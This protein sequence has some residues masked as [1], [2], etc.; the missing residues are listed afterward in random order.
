MDDL[1]GVIERITFSNQMTGYTVAKL[2]S[3]KQPD[4]VTVV[5]SMPGLKPGETVRC[6]GSWKRHL[7]HGSQ[8]VVAAVKQEAPSDIVGIRKYLGSGLIKGIGPVYAEK[9][10]DYFGI[11]TLDIISQE[12]ERLF[13][14]KGLGKK[15]VEKIID[16][17][18]EQESIRDVMVFLQAH[19]VSPAYA[20]KIFRFYKNRS[21]EVIQENPYRL[22]REI[23]GIGFKMADSIAQSLGFE[24]ESARRIAAGVIYVLEQLA[25]EGH[26]CFPLNPFVEKAAQILEIDQ[27]L[28]QKEIEALHTADEVQVE[29][30]VF[31]GDLL[32]FIW[33]TVAYRS[34]L[35]IAKLLREL[36]QSPS[37]LRKVDG[38][39]ALKWVENELSIELATNQ[40]QAVEMALLEKVSLIT[41]GPGTGKSTIT[42]AILA[43]YSKLT[44]NILLLAPTGRAAKRMQEITGQNAYTIHAKL[45]VDFQK[46]GFRRGKDLPLEADLIIC[47]EA[48][49]VDTNLFYSLLK[50]VPTS[51]HLILVGDIFQ[52]PSVG[53]GNVLKDLIN[54]NR[55]STVTLNQIF[56]QAEGSRIITNSHLINS[57]TFPDITNDSIS[58]FFFISKESPEEI[59]EA[60][61]TL[62]TD[63]LPKKYRLHPVDEI[64]IL[65]PM[66][67]G[68]VGIENLNSVLQ[69]KINP[70][71][72]SIFTMGR[73]FALND[74][75][76]QIRN[77]Y[78]KEIYNGD[79]GRI[80][81][82]DPTDMRLTVR[83]DQREVDYEY[84][85]LD[86]LLLAYAVSVHKYQGSECPCV[87]IPVHTSHFK[88]LMRNL[89]YTA[90]TRGKKLVILVGSKRALALAVHNADPLL[91]YT[92]L[93]TALNS[94]FGTKVYI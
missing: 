81:A 53:S 78:K 72:E 41:G 88:L 69:E 55:I 36:V 12:P 94:A 15:K 10:V 87:I 2:K 82:L 11:S 1:V 85:E 79:I 92:G 48:S 91:R 58:D 16:C 28:V 37:N 47:D 46:G 20:Q 64:Q 5:G 6:Q 19:G 21:I 14:I 30:M 65:S 25:Q 43:L 68:V 77:N 23:F 40:K 39:R 32:K 13:E 24:K 50:A 7:I 73:K 4:L 75:V 60:I 76:M 26:T 74:K 84:S 70:Q 59:L 86:E 63:R 54:S 31:M 66:K 52:L 44:P 22:A 80:V 57:G 33:T 49:M 29:E 18:K 35:G 83:F 3:K 90:V 71:K 38:K 34:E 8:F 93:E 17:W 27:A 89:L 62:V 45:E 51:A 61:L 67:K 9:I 42:K 56:R